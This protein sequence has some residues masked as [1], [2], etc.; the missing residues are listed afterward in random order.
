MERVVGL[1]GPGGAQDEGVPEEEPVGEREAR[2]LRLG[3]DEVELGLGLGCP[4]ILP[5]TS[6]ELEVEVIRHRAAPP[7]PSASSPGLAYSAWS[8]FPAR[9]TS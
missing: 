1:P 2:A 9:R 7:A 5:G 3:P 4:S 8:I 6:P